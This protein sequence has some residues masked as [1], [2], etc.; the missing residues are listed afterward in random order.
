MDFLE[1]V[2]EWIVWGLV[3]SGMIWFAFGCYTLINLFFM[4]G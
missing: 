4:K 2:V 1:K 3:I